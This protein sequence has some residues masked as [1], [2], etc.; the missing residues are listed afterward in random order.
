MKDEEKRKEMEQD[1][2][3]AQRIQLEGAQETIQNTHSSPDAY[4]KAKR[5]K[6]LDPQFMQTHA[7]LD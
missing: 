3:I 5:P 4:F 1:M 7:Q 2:K 6:K